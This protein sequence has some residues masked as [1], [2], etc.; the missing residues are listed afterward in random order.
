MR[1]ALEQADRPG[2][3]HHAV[4]RHDETERVRLGQPPDVGGADL[5]GMDEDAVLA[6]GDLLRRV[7]LRARERLHVADDL[8]QVLVTVR[9]PGVGG[10]AR[11]GRGPDGLREQDQPLVLRI[12]E[13]LVALRSHLRRD[14][15]VV[16]EQEVPAR[17]E[18]QRVA[19][20][21][22][23][24]HQRIDDPLDAGLL[25]R[26]Q[27]AERLIQIAR[28]QPPVLRAP[29]RAH[30]DAGLARRALGVPAR[31]EVAGAPRRQ[32]HADAV[33]ALELPA[34]LLGGRA[35]RAEE[36]PHDHAF[37]LGGGDDVVPLRPASGPWSLRRPRRGRRPAPPRSQVNRLTRCLTG[38]LLG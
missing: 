37:L 8:A 3:Q 4:L 9:A 31:L 11:A 34:L 6:A 13:I 33:Q 2:Q 32:L 14:Q 16:H 19:V 27:R 20:A 21:R 1:R 17:G 35:G 29:R 28:R 26:G 5:G 15:L 18:V 38:T 7:D 10:P 12:L 23:D 24:V 25:Q 36:R 30:V 22:L